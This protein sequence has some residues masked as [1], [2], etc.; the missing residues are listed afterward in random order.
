MSSNAPADR[1]V[2]RP[3]AHGGAER[4]RAQR[5]AG[6]VRGAVGCVVAALGGCGQPTCAEFGGG[7]DRCIVGHLDAV[8]GL[9]P[10]P[11]EASA[12]S[13]TSRLGVADAGMVLELLG[14]G[15]SF[16][17]ASISAASLGA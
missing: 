5:V 2:W 15:V 17:Q 4:E 9:V 16:V 14:R 10:G 12:D 3:P 7:L 6:R 11:E 8:G 13:G 1:Q